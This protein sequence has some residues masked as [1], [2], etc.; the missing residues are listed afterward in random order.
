MSQTTIDPNDLVQRAIKERLMKED[1]NYFTT[2]PLQM[3]RIATE[4]IATPSHTIAARKKAWEHMELMAKL[5]HGQVWRSRED[6]LRKELVDAVMRIVDER[7]EGI[8]ETADESAK[9]LKDTATELGRV[10]DRVDLVAHKTVD[11]HNYMHPGN[12]PE[13]GEILSYAQIAHTS[14]VIHQFERPKH[15]AVIQAGRMIDRKFIVR[16]ETDE[17]WT[18]SETALLT[19]ANLALDML[20]TEEGEDKEAKRVVAV[21]KV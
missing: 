9:L 3:M 21:Q 16:S 12:M 4:Q 17:D 15:S 14:N 2:F 20:L 1:D 6:T 13:E 19:K 18:L 5:M 8:K 10:A 11:P 7:M